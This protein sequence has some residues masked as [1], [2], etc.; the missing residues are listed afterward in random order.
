MSIPFLTSIDMNKN[1]I[2]NLAIQK[3]ATAPANPVKSQIY[4]NTTD[5][6]MYQYNGSAW[7]RVGVIYDM[8]LGTVSSNSVPIKLVGNDGTTDTVTIKGSGGASLSVSGN[9]LTITTANTNTT[10]TF[11][12]ST[13]ADKFTITITPSSGIATTITVPLAT[14]SLAG[15]MSPAQVSKLNDVAEGANKTTV[16]S[17][18]SNSSTNPV[19]NKAIKTV[20]DKKMDVSAEVL[21]A[22]TGMA[23]PDTYTLYTLLFDGKDGNI[24]DIP[25]ATESLAGLMLPAQVTKLKGLSNYSHPTG[26]G[27]LHVPATGTGNNGKVLKAGGT[28]G[29]IAWAALAK[30]DVGLGN[31]DNTSDANK[32]VSIAQKAALDLKAP[33]ASPAFTGKPT[34]PTPTTDTGI[35]N[36]KYVDDSI[37]SGIAASD[38]MIFKGTIGT[39]GNVTSLPT[40]YKTGWTYRVITAGTY[41]GNV[42]EVGDLI[43]ALVDRTGSGNA[44]SDWTVAQTNINGAITSIGANSPISVSGSGASRTVSHANSGV[45]AGTYGVVSGSTLKVPKVAV[46]ATGHVTEVTDQT[47]VVPFVKTYTIAAG[48]TS[49]RDTSI[50]ATLSGYVARDANSGEQLF[51]DCVNDP[52][53]PA[54]EFS[55]ASAYANNIIITATYL[56]EAM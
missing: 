50:S 16:D 51:L 12:S 40:T 49:V 55:I 3:L 53:I 20:L 21:A 4:F 44:N 14:T 22:I 17:E 24:I 11:T 9:T 28:A 35:A 39:G 27:N 26:D 52:D 56:S 48:Q 25:A 43:I 5:N 30:G 6:Y 2:L 33:L 29:S 15:L 41:A 36:K 13:A 46:N 54:V 42:C 10:Y 23:N 32:P 31:V 38:A 37:A 18:L 45:T 7:I 8:S 34:A 19:Q 1:E 47:V